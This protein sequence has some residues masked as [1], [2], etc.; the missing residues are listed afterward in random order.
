MLDYK[1]VEACAEVIRFGSFEKAARALGLTQSAISQRVKLMEERFGQPVL[2]R[3]KPIV[4]TVAGQRLLAHY[5]SVRLLEQDL[6]SEL[7]EVRAEGEFGQ[8]TLAVN[9]DSLA[10]WFVDVPKLLFEK[11]GVLVHLVVDDESLNHHSLQEG[12]VLGAVSLRDRPIQGCRVRPLGSMRYFMVVSPEFQERYFKDGLTADALRACPAVNFSEHDELQNQFLHQYFGLNP[13]EFPAHTVPS[14]QGF[15]TLAEQGVAYA[16]VEQHQ[17]E[18][19]L[20]TG[21]LVRPCPFE[22]DRPLY[23]HHKTINSRLLDQVNDIV[24]SEARRHLPEI[25]Q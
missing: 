6:G 4:P 16:V 19:G 20:R 14:S 15:V 25:P 5:Q 13:G 7:P 2:V 22:I 9:A 21:R 18:E 12:N 8:V 17:A 1:L 24:L 23:W 10:T 11:L 3:A